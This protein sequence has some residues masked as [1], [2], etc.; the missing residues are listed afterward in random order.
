[1]SSQG[2]KELLLQ[3]DNLALS[4]EKVKICNKGH[5]SMSAFSAH[6]TCTFKP[7]FLVHTCT[8]LHTHIHQQLTDP[9]DV[10]INFRQWNDCILYGLKTQR[11]GNLNNNR[12]H[13]V[14][15]QTWHCKSLAYTIFFFIHLL[16]MLQWSQ[17]SIFHRYMNHSMNRYV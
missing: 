3:T 14:R 7:M 13:F 11:P 12:T 9:C 15:D 5:K 4:V 17:N 1:M 2:N 10:A 16:K 6:V 8:W